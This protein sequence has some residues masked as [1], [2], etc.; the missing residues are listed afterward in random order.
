MVYVNEWQTDHTAQS[1]NAG[2]EAVVDVSW[3][4]DPETVQRDFERAIAGHRQV[5]PAAEHPTGF[6]ARQPVRNQY[7]LTARKVAPAGA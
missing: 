7:W 2:P 4:Y 6:G 1:R 3:S 5:P